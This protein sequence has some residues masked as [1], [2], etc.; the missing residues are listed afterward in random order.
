MSAQ[1]GISKVVRMSK[2][3]RNRKR[4]IEREI[5][6]EREREKERRDGTRGVYDAKA[7][8]ESLGGGTCPLGA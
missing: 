4:E 2:Q 7:I 8:A 6:R 1:H 3:R 5:E